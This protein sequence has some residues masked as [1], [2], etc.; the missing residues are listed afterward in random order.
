MHTSDEAL[1]L[2]DNTG[3]VERYPV[4]KRRKMLEI[5]RHPVQAFDDDDVDA[6]LFHQGL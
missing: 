1:G 3:A 6:R 2:C 5:S 4:I